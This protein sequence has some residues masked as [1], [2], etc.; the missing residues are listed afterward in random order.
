M[1]KCC[2][3][4]GLRPVHKFWRP[5][6]DLST[7]N[8]I[9]GRAELAERQLWIKLCLKELNPRQEMS[10]IK[11]LCA[12]KWPWILF[13]HHKTQ[14]LRSMQTQKSI[15]TILESLYLLFCRLERS[16]S[17]F[18]GENSTWWG[19]FVGN[20][21]FPAD[22]TLM[23]CWFSRAEHQEAFQHDG[24]SVNKGWRAAWELWED[25]WRGNRG[26]RRRN[27]DW[28]AARGGSSQWE[29]E[30]EDLTL[31]VLFRPTFG[32]FSTTRTRNTVDPLPL[33]CLEFL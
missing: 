33:Q 14:L 20:L 29:D 6:Q 13:D 21:F 9:I 30:E 11:R 2:L 10:K 19:N 7:L 32:S 26:M 4:F 23:C 16:R 22:L 24:I 27:H 3:E 1:Q 8:V 5:R 31:H 28:C 15:I 17:C 18:K 12:T 25:W